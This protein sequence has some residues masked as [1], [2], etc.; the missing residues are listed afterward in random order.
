MRKCESAAHVVPATEMRS[1][2]AM[3]SAMEMTSAMEMAPTMASA[4]MTA[5]VAS[6]TS[7]QRG[8]R[9]HDRQ[10]NNHSPNRQF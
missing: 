7:A 4:T 9:Q 2:K 5:A 6:A 3:A 1:M 8:V 10:R